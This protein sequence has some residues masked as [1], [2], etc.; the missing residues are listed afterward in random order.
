MKP[1]PAPLRV[2]IVGYGVAGPLHALAYSLL[3]RVFPDV[4]RMPE[5]VLIV[6][7]NPASLSRARSDWPVLAHKPD[8]GLLDK[9]RIDIVD[10][11]VPT[12]LHAQVCRNA[13]AAGRSVLCEKPLTGNSE[14]SASLVSQAA[15]ARATLGVNFNFRFVPALREA[16]RLISDG[17]LGE[18][19]SLR[20]DYHRSSNLTRYKTGT[21]PADLSRGA[22]L[23][24]GPHAVDLVHFLF[25]RISSVAARTHSYDAGRTSTVDDVVKLEVSLEGGALGSIEVSKITPGAVNDLEIFAYGTDASVRF[26]I[27]D[28][29]TLDLFRGVHYATAHQRLRLG[30][31]A[32]AEATATLPA[33]SGSSVLLWH[34]ASIAAF[35][36]AMAG[37]DVSIATGS[38]GLGVDLVLEAA[39]TSAARSSV[40][41]PVGGAR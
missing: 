33:E 21:A 34:T 19:R 17:A 14:S 41:V 22:L 8:P 39:Q 20:V 7:T 3:P 18:I 5:V 23:D 16:K 32:L 26:S 29:D 31:G 38:D 12:G 27:R 10:C 1:R 13:L 6:D 9:F 37:Q 30:S 15:D 4:P 11:C 28:P 24:L 35:A 36:R 25:G 2:A 40:W